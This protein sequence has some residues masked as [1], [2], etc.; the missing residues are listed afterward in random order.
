M[1][2]MGRVLAL[3]SA[4]VVVVVTQ[5]GCLAVAAAGAAG[6]TVA[7]VKGDVEATVDAGVQQTYD[8]TKAAME[9]LKLPL[10][11][12]SVQAM[13][14]KVEARVGSDNKATVDIKGQS[15]KLS[16]INIRVGTFGDDGLSQT[17]LAKIRAH[18]GAA[19]G[20]ALAQ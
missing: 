15:E 9:E 7:Y 6:G 16:K 4:M 19:G 10:L 8:A 14:A 20:T 5:S 3:I 13:Q 11:S 12:S 17:I 1:N 2:G 18:L